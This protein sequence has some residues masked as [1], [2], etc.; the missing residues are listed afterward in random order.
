MGRNID[1]LVE[2]KPY[3]LW[4]THYRGKLG[5]R[6]NYVDDIY[7]LVA[8]LAQ[9]QLEAGFY[10]RFLFDLPGK[11]ENRDR[12]KPLSDHS[13]HG[14]STAGSRGNNYHR[15][16]ARYA[17]ISFSTDGR[18]LFMMIADIA[19]GLACTKRVVEMHGTATGNH[20][21]MTNPIICEPLDYVVGYFNQ[22]LHPTLFV[23]QKP[24]TVYHMKV[25]FIP[26]IKTVNGLDKRRKIYFFKLGP[27]QP[28][29]TAVLR[30]HTLL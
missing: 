19:D 24:F 21:Y 18:S 25:L 28:I 13:G 1:G 5:H 10:R 4:L 14:V 9:T 17:R 20:K 7:F 30:P 6:A 27:Q 11:I 22:D 15:K 2:Q 29:V 12:I 26:A 8:K 23:I 16:R 3:F